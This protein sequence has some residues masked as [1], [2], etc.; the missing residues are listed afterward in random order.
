M[1]NKINA[2][3]EY[4]FS[5]RLAG[6]VLTL[7][8]KFPLGWNV[9][10]IIDE[11]KSVE[12]VEQDK[13]AKRALISILTEYSEEGFDLLFAVCNR[14]IKVN[15][16]EELKRQL[17]DE[18]MREL[19]LLFQNKSLDELKDINL[20]KNELDKERI[21]GIELTGGEIPNPTGSNKRKSNKGANE[22][23]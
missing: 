6:T 13:D 14:I 8:L 10:P 2:I 21:G 18:K 15:V 19:Q 11:F 9:K 17:F 12:F 1:F 7:D 3:K 4:F 20:I 23:K 16:E 5:I 22:D